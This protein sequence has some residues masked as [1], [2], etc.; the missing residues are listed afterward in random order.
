MTLHSTRHT[1]YTFYEKFASLPTCHY[2]C[3]MVI[4][5]PICHLRMAWA[6]NYINKVQFRLESCELIEYTL[7]MGVV[8]GRLNVVD[9]LP[10]C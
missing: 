9:E 5:W 6:K 3:F 4:L 8:D 1:N 2:K 10:A 7:L